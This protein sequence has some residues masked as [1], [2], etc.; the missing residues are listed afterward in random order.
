[1]SLK[2]SDVPEENT[3][4]AFQLFPLS[5]VP[6][7]PQDVDANKVESLEIKSKTAKGSLG[8]FVG[9][10]WENILEE[11]SRNKQAIF[12]ILYKN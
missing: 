2:I 6:K 3:L 10:H 12:L 5:V 11:R 1:M 9:T 8:P 7:I 4:R